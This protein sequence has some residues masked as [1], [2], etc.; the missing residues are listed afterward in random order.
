MKGLAVA[1]AIVRTCS[2]RLAAM[3]L[4]QS[5]KSCSVSIDPLTPS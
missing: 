4:T 3:I 2:V 5:V 1:C